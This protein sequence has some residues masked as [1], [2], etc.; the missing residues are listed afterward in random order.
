L[1]QDTY[2]AMAFDDTLTICGSKFWAHV[3]RVL[4]TIEWQLINN[5]F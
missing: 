5:L 2:A 1:S 3:T 4:R